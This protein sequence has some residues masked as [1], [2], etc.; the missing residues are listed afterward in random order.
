VAE[1]RAVQLSYLVAEKLGAT[2]A[3]ARALQARYFAEIYPN[4]RDGYVSSDCRE[5]GALDIF[6]DRTEFP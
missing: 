6:P 1:C 2:E 5:G 4:L 3:Q